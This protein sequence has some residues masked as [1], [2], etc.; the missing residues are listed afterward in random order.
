MTAAATSSPVPGRPAGSRAPI[1]SQRD[2]AMEV[3]LSTGPGA[4]ALTRT[5]GASARAAQ[6][7]SISTPALL[8]GLCG[9]RRHGRGAGQI[10]QIND[11]AAPGCFHTQGGLLQA[12]E[13]T[14]EVEVD[15]PS[16]VILISLQQI[17]RLHDGGRIDQQVK[18]VEALI[19]ASKEAQEFALAGQ[20]GLG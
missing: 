17:D 13:G 15:R 14:F 3:G 16:P 9:E 6:R 19:T 12:K 20:I 7:G 10:R 18:A 8:V 2:C 4:T 11:R 5:S 1:A